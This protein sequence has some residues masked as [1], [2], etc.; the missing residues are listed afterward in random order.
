MAQ[1]I[2]V[3]FGIQFR[4]SD[5]PNSQKLLLANC[6]AKAGATNTFTFPK[7]AGAKATYEVRV[8][9]DLAD[10]VKA[11]DTPGAI[12][13]YDGHS[14]FGR[15]PCFGP[16]GIAQ[17]PDAKTAPV[18]PWN[19]TYKM[20]YDATDTDC[21][22]D[23]VHHSVLSTEYDLRAAA[24]KAFLGKGLV[25]AAA[26]V[27]ANEKAYKAKKIKASAVCGAPGFWREFNACFTKLAATATARGDKP[28]KD[29][30]FYQI[31]PG[32]KTTEFKASIAVGAADLDKSKLPGKLLVMGSCSSHVHFFDALDR[33]RKAAKSS[34][35]FMLT[36]DV[37]FADLA[38][39]FLDRVLLKKIDPGTSAGMAR[40]AKSLNGVA[41]S[42]GVGL[43]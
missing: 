39:L 23:L 16:A 4:D 25:A 8:K 24:A 28:L 43:Y 21:M 3:V 37:C 38:T 35:K 20:G 15:G 18:N 19:I 9:F 33:R 13:V 30:H 10:F 26:K 1:L 40:L 27:Q 6:D 32:K 31:L 2:I 5:W 14:R 41:G 17:M 11:V 22:G 36:G 12:V 29:R 7:G 42:G 34:C